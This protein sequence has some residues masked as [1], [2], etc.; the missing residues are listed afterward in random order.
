MKKNEQDNH[1]RYL[2]SHNVG[3][4]LLFLSKVMGGVTSDCH[5]VLDNGFLQMDDEIK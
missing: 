5:R 1:H 4:C 2:C 3:S